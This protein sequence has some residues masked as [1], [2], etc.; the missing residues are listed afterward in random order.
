MT[1]H[2]DE[3]K[4]YDRML[5]DTEVKARGKRNVT[6]ALGLIAFMGLILMITMV[7]M[8]E[9]VVL[10]QD[11]AAETGNISKSGAVQ[12]GEGAAPVTAPDDAS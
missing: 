7:R 6:L 8:K 10:K 9:G 1:M 5:T 12:S 11:W 4:G 2:D 3:N